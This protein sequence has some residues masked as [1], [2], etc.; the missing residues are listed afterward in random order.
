MRLN[1]GILFFWLVVGPGLMVTQAYAQPAPSP[2]NG[3]PERRTLGLNEAVD[4]A[5]EKNLKTRISREKIREAEGRIEQSYANLYPQF[6]F[7]TNQASRTVNLAAQGL[8]GGFLPIP[9]LVG[10]FYTFD[11]RVQ[12]AYSLVDPAGA[13][14]RRAADVE[15]VMAV[16]EDEYAR[17]SVL[18][19]TCLDYIQWVGALQAQKAALADQRVAEQLVKLARDQ[20]EVGVAAKVD[21]VRAESQLSDKT[22]RVA[23]AGEQVN[24]TQLELIRFIGMPLSSQLEPADP[25]L[26]EASPLP[27]LEQATHMAWERRLDLA[28]AQRTCQRLELQASAV[29]AGSSPTLSLGAD[30]GLAGTTPTFNSTSVYNVGLTLAIPLFDGGFNDG[31]VEE[32]SSQLRQAQDQFQDLEIQVEQDVRNAL[33]KISLAQQQRLTARAGRELAEADLRISIDRYQAG[34]AT[35][36][37]TVQAQAQLTR[38]Q[39]AEVQAQVQYNLSLVQLAQATGNPELLYQLYSLKPP[40]GPNH[41]PGGPHEQ[42]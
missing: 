11:S 32:I 26:S 15:R 14:R 23:Q 13:W 1:L 17:Q 3:E 5:R 16:V 21:V 18:T 28:L 2:R 36:T 8:A 12:L 30:Y 35:S 38:A 29:K 19:M 42:P 10:P 37:E 33:R 34:L 27:G 6:R 20:F 22:L 41:P 25:L 7:V 39:D 40:A 24:N 4:L 9:V 31:K